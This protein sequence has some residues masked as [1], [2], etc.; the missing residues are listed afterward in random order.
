LK[1]FAAA[2]APTIAVGRNISIASTKS[3]VGRNGRAYLRW[4]R[5]Y[6]TQIGLVRDDMQ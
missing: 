5:A 1:A 4:T 6:S 3:L 2:L